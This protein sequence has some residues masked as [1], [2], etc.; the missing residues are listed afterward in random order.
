MF[1]SYWV[2]RSWGRISTTIGSNKLEKFYSLEEARESF[3]EH[4][5][6][7]TGNY[8]GEKNFVK[9]PGKYYKMEIDY[10]EEEEVRKLGESNIKSKLKTP[11]QDLIKL[12]FDV[13]MMKEMMLEFDLVSK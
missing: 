6:K 3:N 13:N 11:V 10:G 7:Q 2:F 5:E 4:Y 8:F 12:L 1:F 9:R